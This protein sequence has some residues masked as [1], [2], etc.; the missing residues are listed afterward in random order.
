MTK[1]INIESIKIWEP[2]VKLRVSNDD[3]AKE[4]WTASTIL[5]GGFFMITLMPSVDHPGFVHYQILQS[6]GGGCWSS[7]KP[8]MPSH[9]GD[10]IDYIA[11]PLGV[12][13]STLNWKKAHCAAPDAP[14]KDQGWNKECVYFLRAGPFVKIG[15]T[16]GHP[17]FRVNDLRTG[18]PFRITIIAHICGGLKE[19]AELHR[20]FKT[21]RAHGEWFR[22]EGELASFVA[23]LSEVPA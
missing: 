8:V 11:A 22:E 9:V 23:S 10:F 18:C 13:V 7:K 4:S 15:K 3:L 5:N 16:T 1:Q 19:E 12:D 20:R 17:S 2:T 6:L 21:Y 14:K